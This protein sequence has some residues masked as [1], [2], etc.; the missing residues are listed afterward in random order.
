MVGYSYEAPI[1]RQTALMLK[2][3]TFTVVGVIGAYID[4][5]QRIGAY[6]T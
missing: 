5:E 1:C 6:A 3:T 2:L 4:P